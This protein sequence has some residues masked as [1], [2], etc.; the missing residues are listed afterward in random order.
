MRV[1]SDC[2]LV[3]DARPVHSTVTVTFLVLA[4]NVVTVDVPLPPGS[5]LKSGSAKEPFV[6]DAYPSA[7]SFSSCWLAIRSAIS[8]NFESRVRRVRLIAEAK[9]AMSAPTIKIVTTTSTSVNPFVDW[10]VFKIIQL[11]NEIA[12]TVLKSTH[13]IIDRRELEDE[14][15]EHA[16]G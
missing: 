4:L 6:V 12:T 8:E 7:R 15:A 5:R 9:S 3:L 2:D 11:Y 16:G 14:P 13:E 1:V 10:F